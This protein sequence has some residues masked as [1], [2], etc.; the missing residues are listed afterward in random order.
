MD[1]LFMPTFLKPKRPAL[2]KDA[3]V[4]MAYV[5]LQERLDIYDCETG[6]MQGTIF[7]QLDKPLKGKFVTKE[8][9]EK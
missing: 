2:P 4:T 5:P 1:D 3:T 6:L 9:K 7:P 8:A